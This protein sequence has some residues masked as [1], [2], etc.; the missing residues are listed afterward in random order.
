LFEQSENFCGEFL[1]TSTDKTMAGFSRA[2]H[3][4][5]M[6]CS[7]SKTNPRMNKKEDDKRSRAYPFTKKAALSLKTEKQ[8]NPPSENCPASSSE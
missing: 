1:L 3:S 5:K 7:Y 6:I 8:N 4:I 2:V